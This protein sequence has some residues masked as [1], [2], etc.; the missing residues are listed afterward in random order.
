VGQSAR[1]ISSAE[2]GISS[3]SAMKIRLA[4]GS[5]PNQCSWPHE[6]IVRLHAIGCIPAVRWLHPPTAANAANSSTH[7]VTA[8]RTNTVWQT[9]PR[10]WRHRQGTAP[11]RA[12]ALPRRLLSILWPPG[13]NLARLPSSR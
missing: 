7:N 13:A 3:G 5:V 1:A 9:A 8:A 2:I 12:C 6:F 10:A 11:Q 4:R